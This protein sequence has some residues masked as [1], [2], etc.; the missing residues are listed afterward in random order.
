MALIRLNTKLSQDIDCQFAAPSPCQ[1]FNPAKRVLPN[2]AK[3]VRQT[4]LTAASSSHP[5]ANYKCIKH[6][7]SW[8][9]PLERAPHTHARARTICCDGAM[10]VGHVGRRPGRGDRVLCVT[11]H[12]CL[13]SCFGRIESQVGVSSAPLTCGSS[14]SSV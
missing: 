3:I 12:V 14:W 10:C 6:L 8:T 5:S 11:R 7:A 1:T 13:E 9:V 4:R 2:T